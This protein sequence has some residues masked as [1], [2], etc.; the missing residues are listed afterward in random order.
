MQ[1]PKG[2]FGKNWLVGLLVIVMFFALVACGGNK[3]TSAPKSDNAT[4]KSENTK[5]E[6]SK[7]D[8]YPN[9][10]I[11]FV[12]PSSAGGGF[13]TTTRQLQ[14]YF[15]KALG[16]QFA[17]E[18]HKGGGTAIGTK[19]VTEGDGDGYT[20]MIS[21]TPHLQFSYLT[22]DVGYKLEDL[23]PIGATTFDPGVIRV[24]N[25]APWKD[26]NELIEYAKT[27]PKGK[28]KASVSF[29]TS[30]NFLALK[31][32]EKATGVEFTIVPYGGGSEARTALLSGEVD[33]THA[34][35]FNSLNI[36]EGTRVI[37]VQH[38]S[39]D[40]PNVTDNAKTF[41][42]QLGTNIPNNSSTYG[43]FV[44]AEVKEKYPERYQKIVDAYKKALEDPAF[45]EAMTKA[46]EIDKIRYIDPDEYGKMNKDLETELEEVKHL[47]DE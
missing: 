20:I 28:L 4:T 37:G 26:L 6:E 35:A 5:K 30:N 3:E 22:K 7:Q 21:G 40:W 29:R 31:Q 11:R 41:N 1:K 12:V 25:D 36:E 2:F 45:I 15:E 34:G 13:D 16:A 8:D 32:L 19:L 10:T 38:S 39:N 42:E 14:P 9:K 47:F 46:E 23:A 18:N 27:Q 33:L 17:I 24:H 43:I 44:K